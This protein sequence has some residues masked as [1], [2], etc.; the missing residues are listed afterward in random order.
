MGHGGFDGVFGRWDGM[1][2]A[3]PVVFLRSL[4]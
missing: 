2:G 3:G 1:R 4:E